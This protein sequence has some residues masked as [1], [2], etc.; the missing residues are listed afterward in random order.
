MFCPIKG[1]IKGS[2]N[3]LKLFLHT[4]K[5]QGCLKCMNVRRVWLQVTWWLGIMGAVV[6]HIMEVTS[7]EKAEVFDGSSFY[8]HKTHVK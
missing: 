2:L 7:L 3:K 8:S 6:Q 4:L 5:F 1:F